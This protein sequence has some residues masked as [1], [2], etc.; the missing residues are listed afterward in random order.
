MYKKQFAAWGV[1]KNLK[2]EHKQRLAQSPTSSSWEPPD[3][4]ILAERVVEERVKRY[5]RDRDRLNRCKASSSTSCATGLD[6]ELPRPRASQAACG[7]VVSVLSAGRQ[8]SRSIARSLR[9]ADEM[10]DFESALKAVT[11]YFSQMDLNDFWADGDPRASFPRRKVEL[12]DLQHVHNMR[13]TCIEFFDTFD[14]ALGVAG[15]KEINFFMLNK[16]LSMPKLVLKSEPL[17]LVRRLCHS[18][19][20]GPG[21][22]LACQLF[23]F[24]SQMAAHVHSASHPLVYILRCLSSVAASPQACQQIMVAASDAIDNNDSAGL[25]LRLGYR[26]GYAKTLQYTNAQEA[27]YLIE[28]IVS[29]TIY[30]FGEDHTL[31][32]LYSKRLAISHWNAGNRSKAQ[33]MVEEL[34]NVDREIRNATFLFRRSMLNSDVDAAQRWLTTILNHSSQASKV[35]SNRSYTDRVGLVY[36]AETMRRHGAH[37]ELRQI[38]QDHPE[39][40]PYIDTRYFT[41]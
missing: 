30:H 3:A 22:E 36:T 16:A 24:L 17:H 15:T 1:R 39:I 7:V 12:L 5:L 31:S 26:M 32:R 9:N 40:V 6:L 37:E 11:A 35:K 34:Y 14:M 28:K 10:E 23:G 18:T 8:E 27:T 4:P 25:A 38:L 41:L 33:E 29:E 2:A 20:R 19:L 13:N 21:K